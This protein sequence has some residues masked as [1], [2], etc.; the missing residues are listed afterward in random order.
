MPSL[1]LYSVTVLIAC[2]AAGSGV[3][4]VMCG[5]FIC[6]TAAVVGDGVVAIGLGAAALIAT[7][8]ARGRARGL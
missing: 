1:T 7:T 5:L 4:L 2:W 6:H 8:L 3:A